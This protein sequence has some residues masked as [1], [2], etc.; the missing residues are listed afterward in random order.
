[1]SLP[2]P[3]FIGICLFVFG[4]TM[5]EGAMADWSA[6]FLR[7]ALGGEAGV[8]GLGYSIFAA[9][10]AA[11]RFGGD[12]LKRRFGAVGTAQLCGAL[13]VIGGGLL[14]LAPSVPVA[15]IGFAIIGV[16]VSV[17]FPLAVTAAAGVGDRAASANVAVLS[18]VALTGFLVGP[19]LI[20][21]VAEQ[22]GIRIGIACLLPALI[23]SLVLANQLKPRA[24]R[25]AHNPEAEVPGV[26]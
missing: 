2:S 26:L 17:G 16:G 4:I 20:G 23:L 6:I 1:W 5:T 13:A 19:P 9:F 7:D 21:F 12:F 18:F 24:S 8:V 25:P 11:G 10:V 22:S 15:L 3:A 14:Y